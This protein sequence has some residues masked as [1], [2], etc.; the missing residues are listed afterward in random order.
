MNNNFSFIFTATSKENSP[1]YKSMLRSRQ[2]QKKHT[3]VISYSRTLPQNSLL[4]NH[5]NKEI[6]INPQRDTFYIY[7]IHYARRMEY[8]KSFLNEYRQ[9]YT[10][11]EKDKKNQW[12]QRPVITPH[13]AFVRD[14]R[15]G[16]HYPPSI[17]N[18][19][20]R[21]LSGGSWVHIHMPASIIP[22]LVS[23]LAA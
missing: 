17:K 16:R 22:L 19:K 14:A 13:Q 11:K 21:H 8:I 6:T 4:P 7:T 1:S 12:L 2:L 3:H 20:N 18:D 23:H 15:V 10:R 5:H 9:D